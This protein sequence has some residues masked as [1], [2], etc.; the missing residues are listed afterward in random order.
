MNGHQFMVHSIEFISQFVVGLFSLLI[1][2]LYIVSVIVS[3][4]KYKKWPVYRTYSWIAGALC[5]AGSIIGPL[6]QKSHSDFTVHMVGHLFLGMLAPLLMVVGSPIKL[7]LRTLH[8]KNARRLSFLL[9]AW[10]I[11]LV[12][13]PVVATSLNIGGLWILYTTD[14]YRVMTMSPFLHALL[15]LHVFLA[16]YLFTASI[17]YIDP[18]PHR[19][20][21]TYRL[22]VL[23]LALAGHG[24]L[25]KYIYGHPPIG[26]P[27][28]QAESAG[29]IMYYGGDA[30]DI[31]LIFIFFQHWYKS[32]RPRIN[33]SLQV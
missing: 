20:S 27:V 12:S 16:G 21:F 18:S 31:I 26:V 13:H 25:S 5:I 6:G 22:S 2:T 28:D 7:A 3:N 15:H 14:L 19:Y 30:I 9:K 29:V 11:R 23:V 4:K 24:I 1:I 8:V 10:P 32:A 33:Q 17:I